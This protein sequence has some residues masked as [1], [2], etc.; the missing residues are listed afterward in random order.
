MEMESKGGAKSSMY[1]D[2]MHVIKC[3]TEM[4]FARAIGGTQVA[5]LCLLLSSLFGARVAAALALLT[6]A[7]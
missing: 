2:L 3:I 4:V 7:L 5:S 6:D 1:L